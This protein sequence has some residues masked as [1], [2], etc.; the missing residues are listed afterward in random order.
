M[1]ERISD[2]L[3]GDRHHRLEPAQIAVGAP[4]LGEFDAGAGQLPGILFELGFEPLEEGERVGG[5]AGKPGDD[6]AAGEAAHLAG[7]RLDDG[8]AHRHLAVAGDDDL[9]ALAQRQDRRAVP[10][11]CLR[12]ARHRLHVGKAMTRSSGLP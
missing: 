6:V 5:G 2:V 9:A 7:I 11:R 12:G 8:V 3:V 4:I 1:P 10:L